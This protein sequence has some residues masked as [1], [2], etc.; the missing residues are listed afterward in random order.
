MKKPFLLAISAFALSAL[1]LSPAADAPYDLLITG[2][3][4]VDGTSAPWFVADVGV[5]D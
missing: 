1:A 5:R 3:R 4:V 2:G